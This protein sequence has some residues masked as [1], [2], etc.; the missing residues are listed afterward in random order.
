MSET[1]Y[2]ETVQERTCQE[3]LRQSIRLRLGDKVIWHRDPESA[4]TE[5]QVDLGTNLAS[6]HFI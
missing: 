6:C 1:R 4:L 3:L 5:V 2:F